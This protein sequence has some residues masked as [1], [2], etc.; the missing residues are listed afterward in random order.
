MD[1][2]FRNESFN[3]RVFFVS[4]LLYAFCYVLLTQSFMF[5]EVSWHIEGAKRMLL[6]GT[7]LTNLVDDNSPPVFMF[8]IPYA[9]L[10]KI[11]SLATPNIASLYILGTYAIASYFTYQVLKQK[12]QAR[13]SIYAFYFASIVWSLF[14]G[15]PML[16]ERESIIFCFIA[17]YLYINLLKGNPVS[18]RNQ[19]FSALLAAIA[20]AQAP[21]Y[22]ILPLAVDL[23]DCIAYRKKPALYQ[24]LFYLFSFLIF[25]ISYLLYP[26]YYTVLLK[27]LYH[28]QAGI[29]QTYKLIFAAQMLHAI[30]IT[31]A[32][33]LVFSI[34]FYQRL[35]YL[36]LLTMIFLAILIYVL[37]HK[38]WFYHLYP[39][40]FLSALAFVVIHIDNKMS[41][42]NSLNQTIAKKILTTIL[43]FSLLFAFSSTI[44]R[45][46]GNIR[47]FHNKNT[48]LNQLIHFSQLTDQKNNKTLSF[49]TRVFPTYLI[50]LYGGLNIISP[51]GNNWMLPALV[52]YQKN[53]EK[54]KGYEEG[55]R[56]LFHLTR[57]TLAKQ[58]PQ[59][60]FYFKSEITPYI[61]QKNFDVI[62][63]LKAD[64]NIRKALEYYRPYKNI[65]NYVILKRIS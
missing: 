61:N 44:S 54:I 6:G 10:S 46:I 43:G 17:P 18:T 27:L 20:I 14:F 50:K 7:Y 3:T 59:Y 15:L 30:L 63:Y 39:V 2:A 58:R 41:T 4:L 57:T 60:I 40:F 25:G 26:E 56:L 62:Q 42:N 52:N 28:F 49:N 35:N 24:T 53:P 32:I 64:K 5:W 9:L 13:Y 33:I 36:K 21:F 37:E 51:W 23:I 11:R 16:G 34:A 8:Y 45:T 29:N 22:L 65:G 12:L 48:A 1:N 47:N 31:T 19:F 55:K 38:A